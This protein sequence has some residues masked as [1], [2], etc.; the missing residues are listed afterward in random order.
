MVIVEDT[1]FCIILQF[2]SGASYLLNIDNW[3]KGLD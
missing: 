1:L 2:H 3:S